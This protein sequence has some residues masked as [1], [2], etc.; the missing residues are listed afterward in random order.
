M[1]FSLVTRYSTPGN[2]I[3]VCQ[4]KFRLNVRKKFFSE[5]WSV[6]GAASPEKCSWQQACQSSRRLWTMLLVI[7]FSFRYSCK[8]QRV[9]FD[10]PYGSLQL[11]IFYDI[12]KYMYKIQKC[13]KNNLKK[14]IHHIHGANNLFIVQSMV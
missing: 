3:K 13:N 1:V 4:G 12:D 11:E 2:D 14:G 10:D 6:T 7:R 9:G 8:E 5:R